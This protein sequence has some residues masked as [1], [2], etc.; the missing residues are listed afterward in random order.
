MEI[1]EETVSKLKDTVITFYGEIKEQII[2]DY[3]M[4][5]DD[6]QKSRIIGFDLTNLKVVEDYQPFLI[7]YQG[8]GFTLSFKDYLAKFQE[9]ENNDFQLSGDFTEN[10][11]KK[12]GQMG[13]N[14]FTKDEIS[15]L[16]KFKHMT[17]ERVIKGQF[18]HELFKSVINFEGQDNFTDGV[19][20]YFTREFCNFHNIKYLPDIT[21][22]EFL[23]AINYI[24]ASGQ[25]KYLFKDFTTLE[26]VVS[27]DILALIKKGEEYYSNHSKVMK[28]YMGDK[29]AN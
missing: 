23:E 19:C 18:I 4:Y 5:L 6:Q 1:N 21:H 17:L 29:Y 20:E 12:Y 16:I 7:K 9:L 25:T 15:S 14:L 28:Y 11:Y 8:P 27:P 2:K 22:Q 10:V 26:K 13:N 24:I 3:G